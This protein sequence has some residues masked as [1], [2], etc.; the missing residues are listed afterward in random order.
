M[1]SFTNDLV[2]NINQHPDQPVMSNTIINQKQQKYQRL[3]KATEMG[4]FYN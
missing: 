1:E 3:Q 2:V 4:Q